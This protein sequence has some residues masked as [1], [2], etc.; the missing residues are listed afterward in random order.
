MPNSKQASLSAGHNFPPESWQQPQPLG[1]TSASSS[2]RTQ[3]SSS[4]DGDSNYSADPRGYTLVSKQEEAQRESTLNRAITKSAPPAYTDVDG[5]YPKPSNHYYAPSMSTSHSFR[6]ASDAGSVYS[7]TGTEVGPERSYSID[8]TKTN[9]PVPS[10]SRSAY[11][12][13]FVDEDSTKKGK[14]KQSDQ[15]GLPLCFA[16]Q[17]ANDL[18]AARFE[19]MF[20]E[21]KNK[22]ELRDGFPMVPPPSMTRPH[23]FS[24]HDVTE[25]DW[26]R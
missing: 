2:G 19:P 15:D 21:T 4:T 23:P 7:L 8:D 14:Q 26:N 9:P 11:A 5:G 25:S 13:E 24:T 18:G 16:R 20:L 3:S 22:G 12:P 17:P 10:R 1:H 6:G